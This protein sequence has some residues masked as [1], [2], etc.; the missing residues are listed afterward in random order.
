MPEVEKKA[1]DTSTPKESELMK[2]QREHY[3]KL[4]ADKDKIIMDLIE[5]NHNK[6]DETKTE[7]SEEVEKNDEEER[8][9]KRAE[10]YKKH[11]F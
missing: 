3:E 9:K 10:Y 4:L 7:E 2:A 11:I 1:D 6:K 8:K 5:N